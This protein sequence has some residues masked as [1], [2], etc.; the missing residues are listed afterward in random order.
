M[1]KRYLIYIGTIIPSICSAETTSG[2]NGDLLLKILGAVFLFII[3]FIVW[4]YFDNNRD[5]KKSDT[6]GGSHITMEKSNIVKKNQSYQEKILNLNN[7]L[8]EK[9][10]EIESLNKTI[11]SKN[12]EI[13]SLKSEILRIS[14]SSLDNNSSNS[15]SCKNDDTPV[16]G[17]QR[18][19]LDK[20][21][22][23]KYTSYNDL[24]VVNGNLI[25]AESEQTTYY[26]MW[27]EGG[28]ILFE[29]VNNDRTRKAI[30]NRTIIIEP[31]CIKLEDSKSPDTSEMIE[32]ITPGILN[33]DYS[34][35]KK[36]EIIY[37]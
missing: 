18:E 21:N 2:G 11:A 8:K 13:E 33:D 29:F 9:N 26:R 36:A 35:R 17:D 15:D 20:N 24:T 27:C 23:N 6:G 5:N 12:K 7:E 16:G 10:E 30:N 22:L 28:E 4:I 32:T 37:K 1:K 14:K 31:F 25:K 34:L 19:E 3:L